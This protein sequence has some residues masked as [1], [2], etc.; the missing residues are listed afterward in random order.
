[1]SG[2]Q[3]GGLPAGGYPDPVGQQRLPRR[4]HRLR[5]TI[6][7]VVALL[8]VLVGLDRLAV[9]YVQGRIASQIQQQGFPAKPS[10][11]IEG[12]P[13]LTQVASRSFHNVQISSTKVKEGPVEIKSINA[14]LSNVKMNSGFSGGTVGHLTGAGVITFGGLSNALG[15][16]VGGPLGSLVGSAGLTLKPEGPH[17]VKASIN[18]LGVSGS[19]TWRVTRVNGSKIKVHL[20]RSSGLTSGLLSSV[21]N[22]AV[23]IPRLPLGMKIQSVVVTAQGISIHVIGNNVAFGS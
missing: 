5:N 3:A 14:D 16:L 4:H 21:R 15:S 7:V 11:S 1:M 18:V 10:V 17:E 9:F 8:V 19:A 2:Y 12:F 22:I 6:I 23:P 13:F 20:V